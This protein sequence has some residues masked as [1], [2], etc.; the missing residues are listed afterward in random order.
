MSCSDLLVL[1][2]GWRQQEGLSPASPNHTAPPLKDAWVSSDSGA[3]SA[4]GSSLRPAQTGADQRALSVQLHS[5]GPCSG[6]RQGVNDKDGR[7]PDL[8]GP[9]T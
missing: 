2:T 4:M 1:E 9:E 7:G 8:M 3:W 5:C 6:E